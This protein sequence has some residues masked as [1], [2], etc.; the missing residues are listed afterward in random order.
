MRSKW[1]ILAVRESKYLCV[2]FSVGQ[3]GYPAGHRQGEA[4]GAVWLVGGGHYGVG[5]GR[6]AAGQTDILGVA[7]RHTAGHGLLVPG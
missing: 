3:P 1:Q 4:A 6:Q 7:V 2:C 5:P